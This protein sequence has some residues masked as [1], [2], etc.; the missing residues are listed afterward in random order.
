MLEVQLTRDRNQVADALTDYR[1]LVEDM[2][3][4]LR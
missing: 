1:V 2:L 3:R 4:Q